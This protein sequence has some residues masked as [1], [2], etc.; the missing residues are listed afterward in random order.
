MGG[1]GG[2]CQEEKRD[3]LH[4][5]S[6]LFFFQEQC[7]ITPKFL[8][9]PSFLPRT[10][11]CCPASSSSWQSPFFLFL[12]FSFQAAAQD[13][14]GGSLPP[15]PCCTTTIFFSGFCSLLRGNLRSGGDEG[16]FGGGQ[17]GWEIRDESGRSGSISKF[18]QEAEKRG[19][20]RK[21]G[22]E[23][24]IR[25]LPDGTVGLFVDLFKG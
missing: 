4:L 3:S 22:R 10:L 19:G 1:W 11:T 20:E 6:K 21:E 9:Y 7:F 25:P 15:P 8:F 18:A 16:I 24:E 13:R 12:F 5:L 17:G 2:G 14:M 23:W